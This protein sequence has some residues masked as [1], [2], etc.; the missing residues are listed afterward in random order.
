MTE[1]IQTLRELHRKRRAVLSTE[2]Q[3]ANAVALQ[4]LVEDTLEYQS[5]MNIAAYIAIRGEIDLAPL[6]KRGLLD[7]KKFYLPV[8][9]GES[10]YFAPWAADKP[11]QKKG[12]GLLEPDVEVQDFIDPYE[13]DLVLAPL[14][15][16]DDR[17][18]RIG[19]GGGYYDRT[20]ELKN[21]PIKS[22]RKDIVA[23]PILMGV[24]H[25]SQREPQL[26]SQGWDVPLDLIVTNKDIYR[27]V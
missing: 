21:N 27:R 3:L 22:N 11:L 12:F 10:M 7:G 13:I 15:V 9:A 20:F 6:L 25:D 23:G 26:R 5:S 2:T 18:N 16:F 4:V 14:V 24:A 19:Q 8:L 17:C 1:Q